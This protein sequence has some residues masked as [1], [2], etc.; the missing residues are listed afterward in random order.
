MTW[1]LV[2]ALTRYE[3]DPA[4]D[5][6]QDFAKFR[7]LRSAL[8]RKA[9]D[10]L[11]DR[12]ISQGHDSELARRGISLRPL[13]AKWAETFRAIIAESAKSPIKRAD[14]AAG[15]YPTLIGWL[16]DYLNDVNEYRTVTPQLMSAAG[17]F[18][19]ENAREIE[20]LC[21]HPWRVASIRQFYL[22]PKAP[23][24]SRHLDGWPPALKKLFILPDGANRSIGT[25]QFLLK[26]GTH[27]VVETGPAWMM[28][29]NSLVE[30]AAEAGPA[31]MRPTIEMDIV[32]ARKT[33]PQP[34]YAG[35]NGWYPWFPGRRLTA[36][37][38]IRALC[39]VN[40]PRLY[41]RALA[42]YIGR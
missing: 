23:V 39:A 8:S 14:Y 15:Y 42:A 7:E 29:E 30:H 25:T 22:K 10:A 31:G 17:L 37:G 35:I 9:W 21:G 20:G 26:T 4:S 33:D 6:D 5:A 28:F 3:A 13:K 40:R 1:R 32:P 12:V 2:S 24:G 34:F 18:L 11:S 19:A 27:T 41:K 36:W 16:L 38:S